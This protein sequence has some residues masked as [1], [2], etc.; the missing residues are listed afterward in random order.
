MQIRL[1]FIVRLVEAAVAMK[2][3]ELRVVS[4]WEEG[5]QG[6]SDHKCLLE[7]NWNGEDVSA[8]D[9]QGQSHGDRGS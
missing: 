6:E 3:K 5:Q 4:Q 9:W 7:H 1:I 2:Q 8:G